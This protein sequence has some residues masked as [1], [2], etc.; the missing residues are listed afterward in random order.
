MM[1]GFIIIEGW[2]W[3]MIRIVVVRGGMR[4]QD[5]PECLWTRPLT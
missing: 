4:T 1:M 3:D 2:G 5:S